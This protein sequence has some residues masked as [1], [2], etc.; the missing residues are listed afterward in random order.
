[1]DIYSCSLKNGCGTNKDSGIETGRGKKHDLKS[2]TNCGIEIDCATY[3]V[4][5]AKVDQGI[6]LI[7]ETN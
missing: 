5:E 7:C 4:H 2:N 6:E 3:I 1:M